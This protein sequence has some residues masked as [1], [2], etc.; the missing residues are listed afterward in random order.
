MPELGPSGSVRGALSNGRPYRDTPR[1]PHM[2][3]WQS[4]RSFP[5]EKSPMVVR[6]AQYQVAA[7]MNV[8]QAGSMRPFTVQTPV[9]GPQLP[10]QGRC[11]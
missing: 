10:S 8:K 11:P 6:Y 9:L 1:K 3:R 7:L 5:G 4:S 2:S